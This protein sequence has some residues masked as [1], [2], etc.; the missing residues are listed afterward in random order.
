[1]NKSQ[2]IS[3]WCAVIAFM[4]AMGLIVIPIPGPVPLLIAGVVFAIIKVRS[5]NPKKWRG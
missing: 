4:A 5:N 1:M 2:K 3:V